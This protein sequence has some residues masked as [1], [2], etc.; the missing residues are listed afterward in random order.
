LLDVVEVVA[1]VASGPVEIE[2]TVPQL[3]V[4]PGPVRI[5]V[6]VVLHPGVRVERELPL[7]AGAKIQPLADRHVRA[8]PVLVRREVVPEAERRGRSSEPE[9]VNPSDLEIGRKPKFEGRSRTTCGCAAGRPGTGP[10]PRNRA[11]EPLT[12]TFFI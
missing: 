8:D 10:V 11:V 12:P 2:G 9:V 3:E 5:G 4:K 6:R 7:E 1:R